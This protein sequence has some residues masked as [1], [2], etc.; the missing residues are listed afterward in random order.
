M[1]CFW[2]GE[3]GKKSLKIILLIFLA[4]YENN[5]WVFSVMF[6]PNSSL[7]QDIIKNMSWLNLWIILK[8]LD[9]NIRS[10]I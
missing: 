9:K 6:L 7:F 2:Y 8:A 4:N 10:E 1:E 3:G 5:L